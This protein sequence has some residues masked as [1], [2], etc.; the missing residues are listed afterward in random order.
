MTDPVP[1]K[2]DGAHKRR[3]RCLSIDKHK[4]PRSYK[5]SLTAIIYERANS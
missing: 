5:G 2:L 1:M 4:D 3:V